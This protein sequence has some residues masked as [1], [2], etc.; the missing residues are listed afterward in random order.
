MALRD[1]AT[2]ISSPVVARSPAQSP[3]AVQVV[4]SV[5]LQASRE[6]EP[7]VTLDGLAARLNV[8]AGAMTAIDTSREIVPPAPVQLSEKVVPVVRSA[9]VSLPDGPRGPVQPPAA[10][11]EVAPVVDHCN[12]VAEPRATLADDAD[13]TSVGAVGEDATATAAVVVA[14]PPAP[15]QLKVKLVPLPSAGVGW[16]PAVAL[17]PL[18]PPVAVQALELLDDQV[19]TLTPPGATVAGLADRVT[20]GAAGVA[21]GVTVTVVEA[22][23]APPVPEQLRSYVLVA[24]SAPVEALPL[25]PRDPLQAPEDVQAEALVEVQASVA[26]PPLAIVPG[27]EVKVTVGAGI[28]VTVALALVLPPAPV[29][30]RE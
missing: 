1:K 29:Q 18:Q 5:E 26:L 30:A 7:A 23:A 6:V 10:V 11:Q 16:V 20:V 3:E 27:V 24:T 21:G 15:V 28:T 14:E 12:C 19:S 22:L 9:L 17:A 25:I 8:G 13:R 2:V 4:A